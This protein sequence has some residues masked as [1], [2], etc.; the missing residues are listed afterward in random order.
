MFIFLS[1]QLFCFA[2]L[3][4]LLI[5]SLRSR[6][7]SEWKMLCF[8]Y[9]VDINDCQKFIRHCTSLCS[10]INKLHYWYLTIKMHVLFKRHSDLDKLDTFKV[11]KVLCYWGH[12]HLAQET[13]TSYKLLAGRSRVQD[14]MR[15]MNFFQFT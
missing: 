1:V 9:N 6:I 11:S 4:V 12:I 3:S 7:W 5:F 8:H 13:D 2:Y 15:W 10:V 14:P